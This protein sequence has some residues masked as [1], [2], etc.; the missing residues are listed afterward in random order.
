MFLKNYWYCAALQEEITNKPLRRIICNLPIV[1]YR[2]TNG[3]PVALEDRCSHRQAPLSSGT[4]RD[5][6]IQCSYHGFV[7][8]GDGKCVY[9]P[10]QKNI[11]QRAHIISYPIK[12]KWGFVWI[13]NG[14]PKLADQNKI[15]SLPWTKNPKR[16]PVFLYYYVKAN[17][18]LVADNLLD[19]SHADYLHS[20]TLGSKSGI[21]DG[22][23]PDKVEF[24]T[25]REGD[26]IH[27]FRKLTNVEVAS[28]P[29]KWG[30]FINNVNRTNIQM[31]EAPNTV[32]VH[33]EFENK[34]NKILINHDHIMT[35]E[36]ETTTHYFMDF[37]RDFGLDGTKYPT[38]EDIYKEQYSV[39]T[40]DDLP[41]IE[42]QQSNIDLCRE[43]IDVPVKADKLISDVH[44]HLAKL[45]KLQDIGVPSYIAGKN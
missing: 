11:P 30:K 19:I 29:K 28:Y 18:Q 41:M 1:F 9:I 33:L 7:F 12:E 22:P 26:E 45:Y 43:V 15:P 36:T 37:T 23:K 25:W 20:D 3:N 44:R 24:R 4:I 38:D 31:W 5:D 27:S 42:A 39:I 6:N 14:D 21:M 35:P 2:D 8:N 13:W 17:H 10:H 34:E 32:H 40:G 16:S